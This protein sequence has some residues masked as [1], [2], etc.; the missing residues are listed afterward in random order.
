MVNWYHY[1]VNSVNGICFDIGNASRWSYD[2]TGK[3][4]QQEDSRSGTVNWPQDGAG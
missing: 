2:S 1:G 4:Q 3:L